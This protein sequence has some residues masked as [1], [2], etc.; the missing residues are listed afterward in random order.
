[1]LDRENS[2]LKQSL[3]ETHTCASKLKKRFRFASS[4]N[5]KQRLRDI[6]LEFCDP[7]FTTSLL[8]V[9]GLWLSARFSGDDASRKFSA[10]TLCLHVQT[11]CLQERDPAMKIFRLPLRKSEQKTRQIIGHQFVHHQTQVRHGIVLNLTR[12]QIVF[13]LNTKMEI[14]A[15]LPWKT[16]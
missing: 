11:K 4:F 2:F 9:L 16:S 7:V 14:F 8:P 6:F 1:M 10:L 13:K 15:K 12:L 5:Q 3:K